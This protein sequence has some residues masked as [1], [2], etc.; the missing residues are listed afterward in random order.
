MLGQCQ[1]GEDGHV[2]RGAQRGGCTQ[3][4][5]G[6]R[7]RPPTEVP[8]LGTPWARGG[9]D[10]TTLV[11][12]RGG[13][14]RRQGNCERGG[15]KDVCPS[16]RAGTERRKREAAG[17]PTKKRVGTRQTWWREGNL[18]EPRQN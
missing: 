12:Q 16:L 5:C 14:S 6:A 18:S 15:E 2:A 9:E 13:R 8:A 7:C 11:S 3:P 4:E 1:G 10:S 17:E